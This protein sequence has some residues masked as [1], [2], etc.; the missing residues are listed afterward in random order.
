MRSAQL[1]YLSHTQSQNVG[2][3]A[4]KS[5][6]ELFRQGEYQEDGMTYYHELQIPYLFNS[7]IAHCRCSTVVGVFIIAGPLMAC[8]YSDMGRTDICLLG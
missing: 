5:R 2:F 1:V 8:V 7:S 6:D 4:R 3:S